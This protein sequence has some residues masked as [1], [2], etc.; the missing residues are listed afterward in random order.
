MNYCKCGCGQL[1]LKDY[2][3]GHNRRGAVMSKE[4]RERIGKALRGKK[5]T[6][7]RKITE[8]RRE[9]HRKGAL[10]QWS[11]GF[12]FSEEAIQKMRSGCL[13]ARKK[14]SEKH[15]TSLES[16]VYSRFE[17]EGFNFIKQYNINDRFLVDAYFP[18]TNVVVEIDSNYWHGL[19]RIIKKD[20]AENAYLRKC[21][22]KV[23]RFAEDDIKNNIDAL[24][25]EVRR[26]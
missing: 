8:E 13:K 24:I 23:I 26:Q 7:R 21:G 1:V 5:Q 4:S 9:A 10:K 15:E 22:Y 19:D 18:Y 11:S 20:I 16:M 17:Q 25:L 14:M 12:S 3:K 6:R 2:V